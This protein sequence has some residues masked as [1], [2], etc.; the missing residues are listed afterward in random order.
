MTFFIA[1]DETWTHDPADKPW[2][3]YPTDLLWMLAYDNSTVT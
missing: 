1:I 3:L 2:S